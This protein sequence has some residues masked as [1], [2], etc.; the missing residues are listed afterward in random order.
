MDFIMYLHYNY[1]LPVFT[2]SRIPSSAVEPA[3]TNQ[4]PPPPKITGG[5]SSIKA[6]KHRAGGGPPAAAAS[7]HGF[8]GVHRRAYGRWAAEIRDVIKGD[9]V[10]IGTYDTADDAARAYDAAARKIHGR[11]AKTNFPF[12]DHPP[13]PPPTK[14]T[15]KRQPKKR[16]I[17]VTTAAAVLLLLRRRRRKL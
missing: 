2:N 10:W 7:K 12:S 15:K 13:P 1:V 3:V 5:M 8:R 16:N 14:T 17:N 9:R 11:H 6:A 4:A